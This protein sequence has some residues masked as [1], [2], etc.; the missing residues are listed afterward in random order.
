MKGREEGERGGEGQGGRGMRGG[1][2]TQEEKGKRRITV[3]LR[4]Q[5]SRANYGA[6]AILICKSLPV[7]NPLPASGTNHT[8]DPELVF[9]L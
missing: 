9:H 6:R 4:T 2:G 8:A 3:V 7:S 1:E 5:K